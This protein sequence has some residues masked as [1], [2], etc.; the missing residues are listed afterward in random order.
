M[1][2][3]AIKAIAVALAVAIVGA[4]VA[5][6]VGSAKGGKPFQ[7][8]HIE[9]WFDNW[10]K[11]SATTPTDTNATWGGVIDNVGNELNATT[12]YEMPAAMAFYAT[13]DVAQSSQLA[14]P[15]VTVT[16]SHNFE[17][18][19]VPIKW[20]IEYPSGA[21]ATD[22]VTVTRASDDMTVTLSCCAP[23]D[24]KLTLKAAVANNPE[25]NATCTIDYVKR[26]DKFTSYLSNN[27]FGDENTIMADF[28]FG[29]GTTEGTVKVDTVWLN[30]RN[31]FQNAVKSKLKFDIE[32]KECQLDGL[33][34]N[35]LS[36]NLIEAYTQSISQGITTIDTWC[37]SDFIKDFDSFDEAHKKA[38][39]YAWYDAYYR[40]YD[41]GEYLPSGSSFDYYIDNGNLEIS[42]N[43]ILEY[44][45]KTVQTKVFDTFS[46]DSCL[47]TGSSQGVNLSPNLTLNGNVGL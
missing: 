47:L 30:V 7:N 32:F 38:I 22:V 43:V 34:T 33:T 13:R 21:S 2:K 37:Y 17:F 11:P 12:T 4:T 25:K 8:P 18:N 44:N 29:T 24:K 15:S 31:I 23:F 27:D 3:G 6:G 35:Y 19:N 5:A 40:D 36:N 41:S 10:G 16:C 45:G 14:A 1:T 26:L 42:C 39:Y 20:T 46:C 9:T 28:F